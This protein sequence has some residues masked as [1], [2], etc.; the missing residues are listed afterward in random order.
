MAKIEEDKRLLEYFISGPKLKSDRPTSSD[1][2]GQIKHLSV[3]TFMIKTN[4][5]VNF[6]K[7]GCFNTQGE[8]LPQSPLEGGC[9]ST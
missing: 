1:S 3:D 6:L 2:R 5:S 7:K 8:V 4:L 9:E